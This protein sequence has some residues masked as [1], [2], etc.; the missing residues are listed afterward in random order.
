MKLKEVLYSVLACRF[1]LTRVKPLP[2]GPCQFSRVE[3][4]FQ[5]LTAVSGGER[6]RWEGRL[7]GT[8]P[9]FTFFW[10]ESKWLDVRR[11]GQEGSP[12]PCLVKMLTKS[13]SPWALI[14][15]SLTGINSWS[16]WQEAST[17]PSDAEVGKGHPKGT[18]RLTRKGNTKCLAKDATDSLLQWS[19]V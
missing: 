9:L 8:E 15:G 2:P 11:T 14:I 10:F 13:C 19:W 4:G 12:E 18:G 7:L 1:L 16:T 3:F 5:T 6:W 17:N